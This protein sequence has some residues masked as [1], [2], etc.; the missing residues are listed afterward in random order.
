MNGLLA[1]VLAQAERLPFVSLVHW[2]ELALETSV[3]ERSFR[4]EAVRFT[5]SPALEFDA[6]ELRDIEQIEHRV[7]LT[8]GFGGLVGSSS[9]LPPSM[10]DELA[11]SDDDTQ[12]ER[13]FLD[14]F[15]HRL[16]GLT[17][18]GLRKFDFARSQHALDWMLALS[19]LPA[20][21]A[22]RVSGLPRELL[23]RLVPILVVYPAN[24][25]RIVVALRA[26]FDELA[27]VPLRVHELRGGSVAIEERSR[28]RLG[29]DL[30]L[31]R[32][33]TLGGR[34]PSPSSAILLSVGPIA[35][36]LAARFAP[37]GSERALFEATIALLCPETIDVELELQLT[38]GQPSLLG[39]VRM[40]TAWLGSAR[41]API[42]WRIGTT[43]GGEPWTSLP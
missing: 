3:G 39:R 1:Q 18:R 43:R 31:G 20:S 22:E 5:A 16:F 28:A 27:R 15:H 12:A 14:V 37:G 13:A 32:T 8:L 17:Y 42:R 19:G 25:T 10:L 26:V 4:D 36:E 2:L 21:D 23:L 7:R 24:A 34:A 33:S 6:A 30:Q 41:P 40:G 9:P 35:P 29:R 11:S 38:H